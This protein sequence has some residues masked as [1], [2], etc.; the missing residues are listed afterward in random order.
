MSFLRKQESR[1]FFQRSIEVVR[2]SFSILEVGGFSHI[3]LYERRGDYSNAHNIGAFDLTRGGIFC[4][5]VSRMNFPQFP[6]G[7]FRQA[8]NKMKARVRSI[9]NINCV[10]DGLR[11]GTPQKIKMIANSIFYLTKFEKF[12]K[13]GFAVYC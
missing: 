8:K 5:F 3:Y 7:R 10:K 11:P 1:L 4:I 12:G 9:Y 13:I 2:R 6:N